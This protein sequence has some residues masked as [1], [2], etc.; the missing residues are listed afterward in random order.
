MKNTIYVKFSNE[1]RRC[2]KIK[3]TII[4]ENGVRYVEKTALAPEAAEHIVN[5]G[6]IYNMLADRYADKSVIVNKCTVDNGRAVFEYI[7]GDTLSKKL[8]QLILNGSEEAV[9]EEITKYFN[10]VTSV[11]PVVKFKSTEGFISVFGNYELSEDYDCCDISNIDIVFDNV[12]INDGYN[13]IDYEWTFGFPVPIKFMQYRALANYIYSN[14]ARAAVFSRNIFEH[15][16]ITQQESDIFKL[17]EKNFQSYVTAG[18]LVSRAFY[19][20]LETNNYN[21]VRWAEEKELNAD[22]YTAEVYT[23]KGE[24]FGSPMRMHGVNTEACGRVELEIEKGTKT[25]RVD[26]I[27]NIS[28]VNNIDIK[29][30][31]TDGT[32]Y[33][34]SFVTNGYKYNDNCFVFADEDVQFHINIDNDTAKLIMQY[35]FAIIGRDSANELINSISD[36]RNTVSVLE[37]NIDERQSV[38][39][40]LN[41]SIRK[42]DR[43]LGE[44][45]E[46]LAH[47]E[48]EIN[49][50]NR[51]LEQSKA[52]IEQNN[53]VIAS[54]NTRISNLENQLDNKD[55][56]IEEI[57]N[58]TC[59]KLTAPLRVIVG[60]TKSFFRN[61]P[62]TGEAYKFLFYVKRDGLRTA[63]ADRKN[64]IKTQTAAPAGS[65]ENIALS[66]IKPLESLDKTI[67]VH[68]HLYYTDLLD[69]FFDYFNNIPFSFDLYVSC[70]GGSDIKEIARKFRKLK[71]VKNVDVRETINRGR[72]IAPLYVQFAPE[73]RNHDYFL[74]VHSKK[75]LFT[76][77]EQYGWRQFNLDCLLK[78]KDTV[79]R[80]FALFESDKRVGLFYPETF[81]E[82]HLIAQDWLAN[83]Y[84]GR[85]LLSEMGIAFDDGLFNYPVG[86]F[87]WAKTDA[88]M[89]IFERKL[90][91]EDFPEEAGQTDGTIA[92]AL[93]RAVSFVVRSRGYTEAI[94]D[95]KSGYISLGRSYKVYQEYFSLDYEAVQYHLSLFELVSFDIFDTLITRLVYRPDDV[96]LLMQDKIRAAYGIDC[97]FLSLRKRAE[98]LAWEEKKEFTS[99]KDIYNKL[100][101]VMDITPE[102]AAEIMDME[103]ELEYELCV[104][105]EDM[106]R[107][108]N[109]LKACGRKIVLVSDMYLTSDIVEK[110]LKK[111]GYEGYDDMWISCEKGLRKD[112]NTMW[113]EFFSVY[114]NFKTIHVGD[115]PRSDIQL[116]GDMLKQTFFVI[117]PVT[118]FKMS[119]FYE[120]F[121]PYINGSAAD[122]LIL[123]MFIN[124]GIYNSPFA[125]GADGEA[126]IKECKTMGYSVFGP[127]FSAFSMWL[128]TETAKDNVLMFLSREGYIFEKVYNNVY[129]SLPDE[130]RKTCYFLASRRAVSVAAAADSEDIRSIIS[131]F[132]RGTLSNMLMSRLGITL[133][134]DI[135]DREIA[136]PEQTEEIMALLKPHIEDILG[137]A[138]KE[139]E[140]YISYINSIDNAEKGI[141]VDVGYSGTIQY[142][143][144]KLLNNRQ[145]G[146]YL[147]TWIDKKPE[148]LGCKCEAMY[149]VKNASEEKIH[150]I[151]RNQL[152]LEAVLKAP[153]GQLVRFDNINGSISPVYKSDNAIE[154]GLKELQEGIL[155]FSRQFG[156][157]LC[158]ALTVPDVNSELISDILDI[159]LNN[160]LMS[161]NVGSVLTVQDDYCKNGSHK[162]NASSGKWDVVS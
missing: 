110:M 8:D 75:S 43:E 152:F 54:N 1:R 65:C 86:S 68:L 155:E 124:G 158:T 160:A 39:E 11:K 37:K 44:S 51:M 130:K 66:D 147:C 112:T 140:N 117:N 89:P 113:T 85:K 70:K 17:M 82:M 7:E 4:E 47:T 87:F 88:V 56:Q 139:R 109:H 23:D 35:D 98:A 146:L 93:E 31:Y 13:I 90:R 95:I 91:Y 58:S 78:D 136:M 121:K 55:R 108:F 159:C 74:H 38:I 128:N 81:G 69:E 103:T 26:P 64:K 106:L 118:A 131:Q 32:E 2:F 142:Y 12:I 104:P 153:F 41:D 10:A 97:D 40:T 28:I 134:E 62:I 20:E 119:R 111:C 72:D 137:R 150:K 73:I 59:W 143:M 60:G 161:E 36:D 50:K 92:H 77:R 25:L 57:Y 114:G 22:R 34:P 162:F 19:E 27:T 115:N 102:Q 9:I 101:K 133:Y 144:A 45:L 138:E 83:A 52:V 48:T 15:F 63:V 132:Y 96:F 135:K 80:I 149:P 46:K 24:G 126:V 5:T 42:Y 53:E 122:R 14:S 30:I 116:V 154:A 123:G 49:E 125:Q 94:N 129:D 71:N 127:L 67:A 107:I 157:L 21:A 120:T 156:E 16:G 99:I 29:C 33:T 61:N 141:L 84:N 6:N 3:T 105:R 145:E 76:G 18:G 100:P 148:K 79:R 151:F